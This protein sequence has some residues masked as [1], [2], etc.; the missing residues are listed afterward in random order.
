MQQDLKTIKKFIRKHYSDYPSWF[1]RLKKKIRKTFKRNKLKVNN[2]IK[3]DI[4]ES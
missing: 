4:N 2:Q 1:N 3:N